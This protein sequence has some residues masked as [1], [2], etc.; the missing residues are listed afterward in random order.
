MEVVKDHKGGRSSREDEWNPEP[1][2]PLMM[3]WFEVAYKIHRHMPQHEISAEVIVDKELP[4]SF[5]VATVDGSEIPNN[6]L[7]CEKLCK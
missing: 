3:N 6:H 7:G 5:W 4:N 2:W 1:L